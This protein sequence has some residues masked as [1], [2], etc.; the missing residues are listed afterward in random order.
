[1]DYESSDFEIISAED[2]IANIERALS[3][4]KNNGA[5]YKRKYGEITEKIQMLNQKTNL[6]FDNTINLLKFQNQL[7]LNEIRHLKSYQQIIGDKLN[8]ELY[9]LSEKLV[10]ICISIG[11]LSKDINSDHV[12]QV[13]KITSKTETKQILK[14]IN[15]SFR[16]IKELLIGLKDY[17][18]RMSEEL[19]QSN[20]HCRTLA[21]DM[22]TKRYHVFM[23]YKRQVEYYMATLSYFNDLAEA[24]I[25]NFENSSIV[26]F[27]VAD[28]DTLQPVDSEDLMV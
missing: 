28:T 20:F 15:E 27:L 5:L 23:E 14:S 26:G 8:S 16:I 12:S 24:I 10:F 1:M 17:S 21:I 9:A 19:R 3:I 6:K 7:I 2:K 22:T 4:I 18:D 11:N 25:N 13:K